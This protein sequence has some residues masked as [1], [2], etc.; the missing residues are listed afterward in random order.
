M[1]RV[2][3]TAAAV[4]IAAAQTMAMVGGP[5]FVLGRGVTSMAVTAERINMEISSSGDV[6]EA[7]S[8]QDLAS[9]RVL[10]TG[11]YGMTDFVDV[12]GTVG[13]ADLVFDN[14]AFGYT[15][16]ES[17]MSLAWGGGIRIGLPGRQVPYQVT[18]A[19]RYM[20]YKATGSTTNGIRTV[21][22]D[23]LW[24]EVT[25]SVIFGYRFRNL[26]PYAGFAKPY[27][28]GT[29][30]IEVTL[31]NREFTA[32]GSEADYTDSEQNMRGIVGLEWLFPEGYSLTSEALL[33]TDGLWT[34]S[35]GLAQK[36]R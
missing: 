34:L 33:T 32:F 18:F 23:Y 22:T 6:V 26:V 7:G 29:K 4:L 9:Q 8:V 12:E 3:I 11:R 20:G 35:I 27:L 14:P 24:Q 16:Y 1:R 30:D 21:Q 36:V 28:M 10:L 2:I 17:S 19:L 31:Q 5:A 13:M 25:P 15:D